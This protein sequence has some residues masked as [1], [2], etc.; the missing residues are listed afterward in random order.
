MRLAMLLTA[1]RRADSDQRYDKEMLKS[2]GRGWRY[3]VGLLGLMFMVLGILWLTG[4]L[5]QAPPVLAPGLDFN[6]SQPVTRG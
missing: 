3:H 1:G 6:G 2:A 4:N 5:K